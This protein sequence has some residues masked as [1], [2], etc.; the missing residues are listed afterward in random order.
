MKKSIKLSLLMVTAAFVLTGC[1]D[2]SIKEGTKLLED[3]KYEQAEATFTQ[4]VKEDKSVAQAYRGMGIAR[5]ELEDYEGA[6]EAFLQA[7]DEGVDSTSVIYHFIGSCEMNLNNPK[8]ALNYYRLGME[9]E[10]CTE[11]LKQEM[12]RNE[13]AAYEALG[14]FES[15]RTKLEKYNKEYPDD[16]KMEK[17]TEFYVT[18]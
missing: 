4:A 10:D 7:L 5:W 17:E 13:I 8:S 6:K 1:V 2:D 15:A 14:D 12:K 9:A 3:K 18:Q 11:E 16:K